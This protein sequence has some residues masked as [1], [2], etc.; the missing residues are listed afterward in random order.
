MPEEDTSPEAL[1]TEHK[2]RIRHRWREKLSHRNFKSTKDSQV[3]DQEIQSF[4]RA[5]QE[6][7]IAVTTPDL[8]LPYEL[9]SSEIRTLSS[10]TSRSPKRRKSPRR[11]DLHVNFVA[12][13]PVIIGEGGDE[14]ALPV[15]ELLP[16]LTAASEAPF[17][18]SNNFLLHLPKIVSEVSAAQERTNHNEYFRPRS[19][20]R[21]STGLRDQDLNEQGSEHTDWIQNQFIANATAGSIRVGEALKEDRHRSR[22]NSA[23][24]YHSADADSSKHIAE[25]G[26]DQNVRGVAW[27]TTASGPLRLPL[28]D[29]ATSFTNS[30]TPL[31]SPQPLRSPRISP[32]LRPFLAAPSL[33]D[34]SS[35]IP[36]DPRISEN[37]TQ[38]PPPTNPPKLAAENRGLS[39]RNVAKGLGED[40]L[41]E[42]AARVQ[43]YCSVFLLGLSARTE[44]TL[45]RW[46]IAASWWFLKGRSELES[47]IRS[48]PGSEISQ[49]D[50]PRHLRQAYVDLAKA[51]WIVSEIIP[52]RH[53]EVKRLESR[54]PI[55]IST[56]MQSF[57]DAKAA[58]LI[59][60]H[61]TV[62]SN[63]RA[64]T[65]SMKRNSR[66]PPHGLE[67]QG[68]DTRIFAEYPLLSPSA[69]RLLSIENLGKI[70]SGTHGESASF[71]P[72]PITDTERHFNYGRMFVDVILD[73]DRAESR[74]NMPCLLSV[75]RD[76]KERDITIVAASQDGQIHLVIQPEANMALSWQDV[77]WTTSHRCIDIDLRA[78]FG[79]RIQFADKDFRTVWGIHDYI[80]AVRK[81]S[82]S[83]KH[84]NIIF[85][86]ILR[87]F[88]H[89]EKRKDTK[90]FP[91][92]PVEG[93]KLRLFERFKV[94]VTGIG[95]RKIHD[96]Y[97]LLVVT[98][99]KVKTLSS[100]SHSLGRQDPIVFSYLRDEHGAPAILLRTSKS[101]SDPS[102]VMSFQQ[103]A[104]RELLY[105]L[106]NGTKVSDDEDGSDMLTL[107][108]YD[109]L[110]DLDHETLLSNR[111]GLLS[112]LAW[113]RLQV[114]GR[115][116]QQS[117]LGGPTL[118]ICAECDMGSIAD[119]INLGPGELQ[120]RLHCD[121]VDRI[122]I[123]RAPQT[124]MTA[125]F[126]DNT[127]SKER[128]EGLRQ[129]LNSIAQSP[130][131]RGFKFSSLKDLHTFQSLITGFSVL[132]DGF[133]K[134]FAISRRRMVVPIYKRWEA[135]TT[136][137]QIVRHDKTLQLVAFFRD[138]S[139]GSCMN[140]VLKS[141][142]VFESFSRSGTSHLCIVDAKF[143]L[144]KEETDPNHRFVNLEMPEYP[145]EHD[146]ITIGFETD[147]GNE[148]SGGVPVK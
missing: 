99:R 9:D 16:S 124:D 26:I 94:V 45:Q 71:F 74:T 88:Q 110:T 70:A 73:Q 43:P 96:G 42:F 129:L 24:G 1:N 98:P 21:R 126:A 37:K 123:L 39:L 67:L 141:T 148:L 72:I 51:W 119:R 14:A 144:P 134:S 8:E 92:E 76:K 69:A 59:Q 4:L 87:S 113:N 49:A 80:H 7:R 128:Y 125:C 100:V 145:G 38:Q 84:E 33:S 34:D 11:P 83:T 57:V 41:L 86:R 120:M 122:D 56:I 146:D 13:P 82:N 131:L 61:L 66:L 28:L 127:L 3:R 27:Q 60:M 142:D 63:L 121:T 137:L 50:V 115:R 48:G 103:E 140:F 68:L 108:N 91:A 138:F 52:A 36:A 107:Q 105:A 118:R 19:L 143:A 133:A 35:S 90:Q 18:A 114:L 62:L 25:V 65:M 2:S 112:S 85:E 93:C 6:G 75:V 10:N 17:E 117:E 54:G 139:H 132:F 32:K 130:S 104:D 101:S 102:M 22:S 46:V 55:P 78:D 15:T 95:E 81:Q 79:V 23:E 47:S 12:T 111:A 31:P 20:Q 77:H 106:L 58:E 135:S 40:A 116:G 147:Q 53:P 5:P 44:P 136:R 64:L 29:P 89:L 97:R 109:V 30:L